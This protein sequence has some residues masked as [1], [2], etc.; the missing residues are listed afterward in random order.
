MET[1]QPNLQQTYSPQIPLPNATTVLVLGIISIVTFC[2]YGIIG[3]ICGIIAIVLANKDVT[4]YNLNPANYTP[5]SYNNVKSGRICAII[6]LV[7]SALT[8]VYI[9]VMLIIFGS[10]IF[11]NQQ[12]IFNQYR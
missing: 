1:T 11:T 3:L 2:C 4:M 10:A 9:I 6:G 8:F 7:L 12:E 5:G